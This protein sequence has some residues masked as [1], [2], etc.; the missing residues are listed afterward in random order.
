MKIEHGLGETADDLSTMTE[1]A[2]RHRKAFLKELGAMIR[3]RSPYT[4][5]VYGKITS[6]KNRLVLIMELLVGGDLRMLLQSSSQPLPEEQSRRI[7]GDICAG[8]T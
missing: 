8:M 5:H 2:K 6:Q 7:L 4:V 3:L 1:S